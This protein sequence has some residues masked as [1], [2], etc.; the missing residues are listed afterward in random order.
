MKKRLLTEGDELGVDWDR[1]S[2]GMPHRLKRKR[3]FGDVEPDVVRE[4]AKNAARRLGKGVQVSVDKMTARGA[5]KYLWVQFA[6][7]EIRVGE[8]C[9]GCGGRHLVR[10]HPFFARCMGCGAQLLL[11]AKR[12]ESGEGIDSYDE[13]EDED[14]YG[15][16]DGGRPRAEALL[17]ELSEVRLSR[18]EHIE[19]RETYRGFARL[20]KTRMLVMAQFRAAS[21]ER[22]EPGDAFDRVVAVQ[23]LPLR[24][25]EGLLD[26]SALETPD[27]AW[28]LVL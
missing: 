3:D 20:G 19:D 8:P 4:A 28:D 9:K 12:V 7:H 24:Q 23:L 13:D 2:D 6:D 14:G 22:I 10:V 25:L 21:G 15:E 16:G 27:S 5:E 11:G 17:R 26:T 1:F 18:L